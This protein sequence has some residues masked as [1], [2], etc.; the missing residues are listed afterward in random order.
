M[1]IVE[2]GKDKVYQRLH[3]NSKLNEKVFKA[4]HSLCAPSVRKRN[5][6]KLL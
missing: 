5:Q 1:H 3:P 6:E 4:R 2:Y